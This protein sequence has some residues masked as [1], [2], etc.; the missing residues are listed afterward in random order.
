MLIDLVPVGR[1]GPGLA[2]L[3]AGI[4]RALDVECRVRDD[5]VD[6]EPAY[7]G[8][9][10]QYYSTALLARIGD[11]GAGSPG[12]AREGRP[13]GADRLLGVTALDLYVPIFTFVFGEAQVGGRCALVSSH[14]LREEFY[15]LPANEALFEERLLKEALHEIGHTFGLR[16]CD[17]WN[18]VM[19]STHA[20]E[21]LDVKPASFCEWCATAR[22]RVI[23]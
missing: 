18:C 3:A 14:R 2:K 7:D 21:R 9:R 1:N 22:R 12:A 8:A 15:G 13:T 16:H 10:G 4:E 19:S 20:V 23:S 11:G 5:A 6:A 17:R